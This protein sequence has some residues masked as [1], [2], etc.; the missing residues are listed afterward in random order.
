MNGQRSGE[1]GV[2]LVQLL[3]NIR[4]RSGV[5]LPL[6]C[7]WRCYRDTLAVQWLAKNARVTDIFYFPN[8]RQSV[9][10]Y[11]LSRGII[12]GVFRLLG[13]CLQARRLLKFIGT[14]AR[15]CKKCELGSGGNDFTVR[16]VVMRQS[17][18]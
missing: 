14:G 8:G 1:T 5:V 4:R 9:T 2:Q 12:A 17:Y 13:M 15:L 7:A 6:G 3:P 10:G 11:H 18:F 16:W